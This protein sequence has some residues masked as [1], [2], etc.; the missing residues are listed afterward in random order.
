MGMLGPTQGEAAELLTLQRFSEKAG[1][2][3][4]WGCGHTGRTEQLSQAELRTTAAVAAGLA[5]GAS[6]PAALR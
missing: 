1:W 4:G 5:G 3:L 2:R 6:L